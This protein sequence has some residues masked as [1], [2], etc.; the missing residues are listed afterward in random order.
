MN[1]HLGPIIK[2]K[3]W[4]ELTWVSGHIGGLLLVI[5]IT[6]AAFCFWLVFVKLPNEFEKGCRKD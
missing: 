6:A 3:S 4:K 2:I 1:F 5:A